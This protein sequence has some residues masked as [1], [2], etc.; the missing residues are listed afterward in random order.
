MALNC[1]RSRAMVGSA[2]ATMVWSRAARNIAN[3]MPNSTPRTSRWDMAEPAR[4]ALLLLMVDRMVR[5]DACLH[6]WPR[7]CAA[8]YRMEALRRPDGWRLGRRQG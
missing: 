2:G 1:P 6:Q 4:P 3:R 7:N 8:P 5:A